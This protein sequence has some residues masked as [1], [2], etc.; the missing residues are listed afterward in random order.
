VLVIP[1]FLGSRSP[2]CYNAMVRGKASAM[3]YA[4]QSRLQTPVKHS[5]RVKEGMISKQ[6]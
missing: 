1:I 4:W 5:Q 6:L 2:R 3:S